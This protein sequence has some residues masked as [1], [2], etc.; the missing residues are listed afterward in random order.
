MNCVNCGAPVNPHRE[1]CEYCGTYFDVSK[2]N[3]FKNRNI[4]KKAIYPVFLFFGLISVVAIYFVFF[5]D[6]SETELVQITPI[7]YFSI[8]LGAFGYK[9][10]DLV[11]DIVTGKA[12]DFRDAYLKWKQKLYQTNIL[13]GLFISILFFPFPF[14]TKIT[15]FSIALIGAL[16]WGILLALFFNGIFPAL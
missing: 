3:I 14:F 8:V 13:A 2:F 12:E 11:H 7:W 9:A 16:I 10:E 4:R 1:N 15:P 5:D 6:L